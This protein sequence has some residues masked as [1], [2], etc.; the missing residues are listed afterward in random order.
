M[1]PIHTF[2][3]K[4]ALPMVIAAAVISLGAS[5]VDAATAERAHPCQPHANVLSQV[6]QQIIAHNA[7]SALPRQP[8]QLAVYNAEASQLRV[9]QQRA[10][11]SLQLCLQQVRMPRSLN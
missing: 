10:I 11:S 4:A 1:R 6:K 9:A 7:T 3:T 8:T 5:P 2:L